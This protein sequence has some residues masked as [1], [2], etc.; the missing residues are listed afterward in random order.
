MNPPTTWTCTICWLE[1]LLIDF[2]GSV[3]TITHDRRFLPIATRIVELGSRPAAL[4]PGNFCGLPPAKGR[5]AAQEAVNHAKADK[6]L[7]QEEVW[8]RKGV[9]VRRHPQPKPHFGHGKS[10]AKPAPPAATW[11]AR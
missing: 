9:E 2:K 6:L 4:V 5:A 8:V 10:C 1:I 3:V 7:A 11:W